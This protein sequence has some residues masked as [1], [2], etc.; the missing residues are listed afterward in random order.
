LGDV[1]GHPVTVVLVLID[2]QY[3]Y[4][5][6]EDDDEVHTRERFLDAAKADVML[7]LEV[8]ASLREELCYT[9]LLAFAVLLTL[10]GVIVECVTLQVRPLSKRFPTLCARV[11]PLAAVGALVSPQIACL[12]ERCPTLR[13]RVG[14]LAA[15]SALVFPQ[16][17]CMGERCPTLRARVG[18]LAAVGALVSL[19]SDCLGERF[20]ALRASEGPLAAVRALMILQSAC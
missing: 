6:V 5:P 14:P 7:P 16:I 18:P 9:F 12:G 11:G 3:D 1:A 8:K 13:A 10:G 2:F 4:L 20:L 17:A 15:V 19:Q